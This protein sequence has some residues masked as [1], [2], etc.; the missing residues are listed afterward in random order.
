MDHKPNELS[1][2]QQQRVA[3]ARALVNDPVIILG[4]EP[5]GNL[6]TRTSEE[7]ML[8]F[9]ELHEE[10]KTIIVVTH[11]EDIGQHAQRVVRFKDGHIVSDEK[12]QP[13]AASR[14]R[15]WPLAGG[16]GC[17]NLLESLRVAFEGISANKVRAGLTML[18][19]IIGVGAVIA[20]LAIAQ[21]AKEQTMQ[22]IQQMGTN[23]L[24]VIPGQTQQG[25]VMG[26]FG[27]SQTLT[28]DDMAAIAKKCLLSP[29]APRKCAATTR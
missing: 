6:D 7:I 15:C 9:Q 25:G 29:P 1:G 17:M 5:T 11:E 23:V 21:G 4:D 14:G 16:G 18:G 26:G 3:I 22:R 28:L 12:V 27:S 2:G 13:T 19:V 10:G 24:M 8:L 20:M